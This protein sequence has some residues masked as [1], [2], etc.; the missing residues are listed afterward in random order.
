[1]R[2]EFHR[3]KWKTLDNNHRL[4]R[5]NRGCHEKLAEASRAGQSASS[6]SHGGAGPLMDDARAGGP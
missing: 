6:P 4:K 3:A 2:G 5:C 1:M